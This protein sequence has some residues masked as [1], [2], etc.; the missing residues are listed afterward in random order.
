M[1]DD[2]NH[3]R[4]AQFH[5]SFD[6][7]TINGAVNTGSGPQT[8]IFN[9]FN[10][11][12]SPT[13]LERL[14][15]SLADKVEAA[16]R[17]T[18]LGLLGV[19]GAAADLSFDG[20]LVS[21]RSSTGELRGTLDTIADVYRAAPHKRLVITGAAGAGKTV[22]TVE[23]TL[24]LLDR[25]PSG[26]AV[27]VRIGLSG[28]DPEVP[29][30]Q[31]LARRITEN[32]RVRRRV[33]RALV[34]SRLIT[35]VLDGL[36][37]LDVSPEHGTRAAA[38][39]EQLNRY[40]DGQGP[41]P[42]VLTCRDLHY[43]RVTEHN[44][45][46]VKATTVQIDTL[47]PQRVREYLEAKLACR[48]PVEKAAWARV[49]DA[50]SHRLMHI[51]STPWRLSLATTVYRGGVDPA[52]LLTCRD[53]ADADRLLLARFIPASVDA[54]PRRGYEAHHT[55]LWLTRL[56]EHLLQQCRQGGSATDINL[57]QLSSMAGP[58]LLNS[59][60]YVLGVSLAES[61]YLLTCLRAR[62]WDVRDL[63]LAAGAQLFI[64]LLPGGRCMADERPMELTLGR[65]WT[66]TASA[67]PR[68]TI[69]KNFGY[70]LAFGGLMGLPL[71]LVLGTA[72]LLLGPP[73][74]WWFA[75]ALYGGGVLA[76]GLFFAVAI[77]L[78][79]A[80]AR[81]IDYADTADAVRPRD[82]LRR[83]A[84]LTLASLVTCVAL[85]LL[86]PY[87]ATAFAVSLAT[88]FIAS[89]A[90]VRYLLVL[91]VCAARKRLPF[92]LARF[93]DWAHHA[94]L[95]RVAGRSYQFR[96]IEFQRWLVRDSSEQN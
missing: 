75:P 38:A 26:A 86:L 3:G 12:V 18:R 33:A 41:A 16:E 4:S 95:L 45:G 34:T 54:M 42:M 19:E 46:L 94:G 28:W 55:S 5:T 25:R 74:A 61:V 7:T 78:G 39:V 66:R 14:A 63:V 43:A 24:R 76:S 17:S 65:L 52:E 71:L 37:E 32:Y 57:H 15:D 89:Q 27:P 77:S 64:L 31:W 85:V 79:T 44:G 62:S 92:R 73:P 49:I 21:F 88:V 20:K 53:E 81:G 23:L 6:R 68:D 40:H 90:T 10:N 1:S 58:R 60:H 82:P 59:L 30:E 72:N 29:F 70:G 51:L 56:A 11:V 91:G 13:R 69:G 50:D 96:H 83:D 80:A 93:L 36:D 47:E 84:V 35:P 87:P 48:P 67:E 2:R 8:N 22:L 9:I